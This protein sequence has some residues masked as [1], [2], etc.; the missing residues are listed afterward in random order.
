MEHSERAK[1]GTEKQVNNIIRFLSDQL[2]NYEREL[3]LYMDRGY[4]QFKDAVETNI[5]ITKKSLDYYKRLR[6]EYKADGFI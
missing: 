5:H 6:D 2:D 3:K 1:E 4:M